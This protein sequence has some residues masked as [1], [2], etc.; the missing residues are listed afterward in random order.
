MIPAGFHERLHII[1]ILEETPSA[2]GRA[3]AWWK[4]SDVDLDFSTR[5][6][7]MVDIRLS[8]AVMLIVEAPAL[9]HSLARQA[10]ILRSTLVAR[11]SHLAA[12][13]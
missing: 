13:T 7:S 11:Q 8:L 1:Y 4:L 12:L 9:E 6:G 5:D 10:A 2:R 3:S